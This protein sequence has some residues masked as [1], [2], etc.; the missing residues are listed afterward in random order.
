MRADRCWS[1]HGGRPRCSRGRT[2][3][4]IVL[5]IGFHNTTRNQTTGNQT[6]VI[7]MGTYRVRV[8]LAYRTPVVMCGLLWGAR[9]A[10]AGKVGSRSVVVPLKFSSHSFRHQSHFRPALLPARPSGHR[11]AAMRSSVCAV[12]G[13]KQPDTAAAAQSPPRP[14]PS[15]WDVAALHRLV[16]KVVSAS[17]AGRSV[18]AAEVAGEAAAQAFGLVRAKGQTCC[19][20]GGGWEGGERSRR[21]PP[22]PHLSPAPSCPRVDSRAAPRSTARIAWSARTCG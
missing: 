3:G 4:I 9:G 14:P 17:T 15:P 7:V 21:V 1:S 6:A 10:V 19:V 22:A 20:C 16:F 18:R 2:A 12:G 5:W 8:S 13:A 11:L